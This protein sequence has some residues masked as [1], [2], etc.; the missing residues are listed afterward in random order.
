MRQT[1]IYCSLKTRG[2]KS[3]GHQGNCSESG[4]YCSTML[5]GF[6]I[7]KTASGKVSGLSNRWVL[8]CCR[9]FIR[10]QRAQMTTCALSFVGFLL[11]FLLVCHLPSHLKTVSS[12]PM[13]Q[14]LHLLS[15]TLVCSPPPKETPPLPFF[16]LPDMN[17]AILVSCKCGKRSINSFD[18]SMRILFSKTQYS[19]VNE[20]FQRAYAR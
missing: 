14:S 18:Y 3:I 1:I 2:T 7:N 12:W 19:P 10:S 20:L 5:S 13:W 17:E 11:L 15:N 9:S 16:F 4:V 8:W 6:E